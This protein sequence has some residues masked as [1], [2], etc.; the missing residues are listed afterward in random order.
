MKKINKKT[1][2]L[3]LILCSILAF[4]GCG[5][6][7]YIGPEEYCGDQA[8]I[9]SFVDNRIGRIYY[10]KSS[11]FYY[12]GSNLDTVLWNGGYVPCNGIPEDFEIGSVVRYSGHAKYNLSDEFDSSDPLYL[13]IDLTFIE[14]VDGETP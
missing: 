7:D 14:K 2:G 11:N 13:G 6:D 8:I 12:I 5:K 10:H 1:L 3:L 4:F 9:G